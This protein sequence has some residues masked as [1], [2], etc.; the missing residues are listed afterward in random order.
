MKVLYVYYL[1][2]S[3]SVRLLT[4]SCTPPIKEN[5]GFKQFLFLVK[6]SSVGLLGITVSN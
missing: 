1:T 5:T 4:I 3:Q 2:I 6:M